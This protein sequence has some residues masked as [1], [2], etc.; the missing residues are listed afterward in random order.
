MKE[1]IVST[2][3]C[4]EK[5]GALIVAKNGKAD[6]SHEKCTFHHDLEL[7]HR[8]PTR[9][10][11]LPDMAK[12]YRLLLTG[13]GED[14]ERQGLLKTPERA[15]KAM[16][17]FT[18]GYDQS[19][20]EVLNNAIFDED[21]DEMVVV[22]DIEMFSMCEH[23]LVP[24]Y[25]KVSIGYLPQGKILGLSKLARIVEI[26]SRRLQ[27]QERL[28]KQI[29]IAV[30]QAVRPAGVAVVIEGVHMCMVM[31]GVQ[32][33]NSKTVTSTML[34]VFRDDPKTREEFL[35][36]V[37]SNSVEHKA[38]MQIPTG[39]AV[40]LLMGLASAAPVSDEK[41][42]VTR[43]LFPES[44]VVY[45]GEHEI[46]NIIVPLNGLNY[47]EK[48]NNNRKITLFF[49]EADEDESG[50]RIDQGLYVIKNGI[51]KKILDYGRDASAANDNSQEVYLAAKDG[52]YLYNYEENSAEKYGTVSDSIIGIAKENDSDV[53]YIL[54][55]DFEVFK[56]SE[57]GEKKEKIEEIV[58]AQQIV[59]DYKNNLYFYDADKQPFV[60]SKYGVKRIE[61]TP[62]HPIKAHLLRPSS[63]MKDSV[64][65]IVDGKTYILSA[66]G[67]AKP[68]DIEIAPDVQLSAYS[69]E[70]LFMQYYALD[71]KIYEFDIVDIF[72]EIL[73]Y[74]PNMVSK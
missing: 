67:S 62:E 22:K 6:N 61:G 26:F 3:Q 29:A 53:I 13:L 43:D 39:F 57:A 58:G 25:G 33:I 24:F 23:H 52:I 45:S 70:T 51:P 8:P 16:L 74:Y 41:F 55:E 38:R 19:L 11:L 47:A 20:E 27:V 56:V 44:F 42:V 64:P 7:D 60:Y 54:T 36:L 69:M 49:V 12:S 28:T 21:T 2:S 32:K 71:K 30:T 34:G 46:V 10:A 17:F 66:D 18:K 14:P 5:N 59:L 15:A 73:I 63:N 40:A 68:F 48:P 37:H 1:L 9:E 50:K 35:N 4:V 31:R 72:E 65:F